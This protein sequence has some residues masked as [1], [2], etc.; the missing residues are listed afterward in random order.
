MRPRRSWGSSL[1]P[2]PAKPQHYSATPSPTPWS[3]AGAPCSH[4]RPCMP[5]QHP[6]MTKTSLAA[7]TLKATPLPSV[8]SSPKSP[9]HPP[10]QQTPS[11]LLRRPAWTWHSPMH[12][13]GPPVYKWLPSCPMP[14]DWP[15]KQSL[16]LDNLRS[17]RRGTKFGAEVLRAETM[18]SNVVSGRAQRAAFRILSLPAPKTGSPHSVEALIWFDSIHLY[19]Y[20]FYFREDTLTFIVFKIIDNLRNF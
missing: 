13:R 6:S 17:K 10:L 8:R 18:W 3:T 11:P 19:L 4:T 12:S 15:V 1:T 9:P 14:G 2:K 20:C 16:L 5:S 7:T